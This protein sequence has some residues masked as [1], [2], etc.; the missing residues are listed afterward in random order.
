MPDLVVELVDMTS[1][2]G[3]KLA[4]ENT[5]L[6]PPAVFIEGKLFGKGKIDTDRMV[7]S[8]RRINGDPN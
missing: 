8:I 3:S 1:P 5:I 4:I 2:D 6:Y 7:E